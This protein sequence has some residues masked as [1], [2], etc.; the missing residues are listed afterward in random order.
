VDA[1]VVGAVAVAA[2]A[3]GAAF[4]PAAVAAAAVVAAAGPGD[5]AA[6][7]KR[8]PTLKS[9]AQLKP[10]PALRDW[11]GPHC[12]SYAHRTGAISIC[13]NA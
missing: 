5:A 10:Q 7:A 2:V 6:S 8:H 3:A 12:A 4:V 1:A 9:R 13:S 11:P